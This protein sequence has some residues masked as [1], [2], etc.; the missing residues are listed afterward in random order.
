MNWGYKI[1]F[2]Y[3]GF[4][5]IIVAMVFVSMRQEVDLVSKD[6][7]AKELK[8]QQDIDQIQNAANLRSE[9]DAKI[10]ADSLIVQFPVEHQK[11]L[12]HGTME[13]YMP[14]DASADFVKEFS[15]ANGEFKFPISNF[16][17]GMFKLKVVWNVGTAS[18]QAQEVLVI[19]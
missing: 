17:K 12:L 15:T 6:Y 10:V 2:A 9:L 7:Y 18:F 13:M 8:Y 4:V 1:V 3:V 19:Q 11:T 14:S 5:L 16:K